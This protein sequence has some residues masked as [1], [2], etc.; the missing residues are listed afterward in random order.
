GLD[1]VATAE[2]LL[3][4]VPHLRAAAADRRAGGG[5]G[6]PVAAVAVGSIAGLL[7]VAGEAAY[8]AAKAGVTALAEALR[9]ELRSDGVTVSV[10][11]PG[12]VATEF[13]SRRN[14]G[15][16]RS[17]P[18]PIGADRVAATVVDCIVTGRPSAVVPA[19]LG[20]PVRLRGL[21]PGLYRALADRFA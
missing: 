19:W 7:P 11:S 8:S 15:Y 16:Q 5:D 1:L 17:R 9:A 6:A 3:A 14:V 18:A 10:V 20:V 4:A 12:V 2:L 13:F 21:A